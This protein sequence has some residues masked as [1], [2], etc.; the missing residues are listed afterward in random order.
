MPNRPPLKSPP[1]DLRRDVLERECE[2]EFIR[3]SGPGGQH[4]NRRETGVRLFHPPSGIE[5]ISGERR[6]RPRNVELAFQRLT[7]A[8]SM[9]NQVRRKRVPTRIPNSQKRKRLKTKRHNA[10][11]RAARRVPDDG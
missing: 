2:L 8:L 5:V 11:R 10:A 4:K 9:R 7:S 1:Y 6:E 3:L